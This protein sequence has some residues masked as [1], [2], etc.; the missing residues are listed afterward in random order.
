MFIYDAHVIFCGL[1]L[2]FFFLYRRLAYVRN[3]L[4]V[5]AV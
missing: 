1:K 2:D 4:I 3:C 5:K